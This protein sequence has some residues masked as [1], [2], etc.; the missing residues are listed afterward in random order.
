MPLITKRESLSGSV[1]GVWHITETVEYLT[2][3]AGLNAVENK[4]YSKFRPEL[5]RKHWLSYRLLL[6][7]LLGKKHEVL[8]DE[9]GKPFLK[10]N[11]SY[12]SVSH[13]GDFSAV[14]INKK[15]PVGIDIEKITPRIEKVYDKFMNGEEINGIPAEYRLEYMYVYWCAKEALYKMHGKGN[16]D[17]CKEMMIEPFIYKSVGSLNAT[18]ISE[19]VAGKHVLFYEKTDDYMLVYTQ[20]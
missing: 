4:H 15:I 17:F 5:R 18:L 9:H 6:N 2:D 12:I 11:R 20:L 8:Y 14:I 13:S 1:I 10:G 19:E 16:L 3:A 7:T